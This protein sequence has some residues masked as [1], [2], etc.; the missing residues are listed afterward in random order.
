MEEK[1]SVLVFSE[2]VAEARASGKP[3]VALE[4]TIIAH[5][6]PYPENLSTALR[7]EAAV[8]E[9]GAVPATIA[10]LNGKLKVGLEKKE[11]EFLAQSRDVLKASRRDLPIVFLKGGNA[12]TT[13]SATMIAASFAGIKLFASGG[14][15]GV[16]RGA[17]ESFDISADLPE[18]GRTNIGVVS[19]GVK[20]ILDI[21]LTLEYLETLGVPVIGFGTDEFPAFY[22]RES[23]F[24]VDRR[25][26]T[27]KECAELLSIKWKCGLDGGVLIAN[28]APKEYAMERSVVEEVVE[29][30][31]ADAKREGFRGKALTPYLLSRIKDLTEGESLAANVELVLCN[32]RLAA[33][34]A[35]EL[36]AL[37]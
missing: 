22:T 5:G 9:V 27:A 28:P 2:E 7:V 32:A 11:I 12:S 10:V 17:Q 19:S 1:S 26:D 29:K 21:G 23:G 16:H 8:R 25:L 37:D 30:A 13:V 33:E 18:I 36:K 6:M 3:L 35:K 24:K 20:A 34:I 15:G 4:S 31:V 14:M